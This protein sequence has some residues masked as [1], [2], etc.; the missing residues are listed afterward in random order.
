MG[1]TAEKLAYL[2]A[3]KTAI[4]DAIAAKGVEVPEGTTFRQ[5]ADL[6]SGISTGLS[7]DAL[8]LANATPEDVL[9]GNTFYARDRTLKTGTALSTPITATESDVNSGKTYYDSNGVLRVGNASAGLKIVSGRT[10]GT[11]TISYSALN[12]KY[13]AARPYI[14]GLEYTLVYTSEGSD[15]FKIL[16]YS[17]AAG[18]SFDAGTM[19]V[20][21]TEATF[22]VPRYEV[23]YM[24]FCE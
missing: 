11:T 19:K 4:K 3:T 14:Y 20:S 23:E 10:G 13:I 5:Y 16:G 22:N 1:T 17:P 18:T 6:I 8:A 9:A 7:D 12:A 21:K 15:D 24:L 2:D